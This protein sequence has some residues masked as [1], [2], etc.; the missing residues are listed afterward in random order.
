[1]AAKRS[2]NFTRV[3]SLW[4]M[5]R[6]L[7]LFS[8]AVFVAASVA[9]STSCSTGVGT[10]TPFQPKIDNLEQKNYV[11]TIPG[12]EVKFEMIAIPGG[13]FLMGSPVSEAGRVNDEGPQHPVKMRPF[14]MEK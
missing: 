2:S 11:E 13:T 12:S 3:R 1:M 5:S 4:D 9:I 14:W 7:Q 8:I 10:D 6:R